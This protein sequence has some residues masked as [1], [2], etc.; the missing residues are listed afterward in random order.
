MS[1]SGIPKHVGN[2]DLRGRRTRGD[3][4]VSKLF[5]GPRIEK[6][7]GHRRELTDPTRIVIIGCGFAKAALER[8]Q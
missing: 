4:S 6:A 1:T 2:L 3:A 5:E 7:N 8:R